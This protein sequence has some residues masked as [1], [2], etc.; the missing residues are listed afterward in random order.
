MAARGATAHWLWRREGLAG[1]EGAVVLHGGLDQDAP[2]PPPR[3]LLPD[4]P[5]RVHLQLR[6]GGGGGC[7]SIPEPAPRGLPRG[8]PLPFVQHPRR[9]GLGRATDGEV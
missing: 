6:I 5:R 4:Q 2:P 3:E 1:E 8:G 7:A 9:H